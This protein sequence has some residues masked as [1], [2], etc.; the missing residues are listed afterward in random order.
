MCITKYALLKT[1]YYN[2]VRE[3]KTPVD[4]LR[5]LSDKDLNSAMAYQSRTQYA[6]AKYGGVLQNQ[7]FAESQNQVFAE[8]SM[9]QVFAESQNQVFAE[10]S[11]GH[12]QT[13]AEIPLDILVQA[14][15][16]DIKDT[17]FIHFDNL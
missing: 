13:F 5:E 12:L 1:W 7:V 14:C 4:Q 2:T 6:Q 16:R 10:S 17:T 3:R 15:I 8:S 9:N 11:I